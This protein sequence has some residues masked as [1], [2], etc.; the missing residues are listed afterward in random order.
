MIIQIVH[1][2]IA[3]GMRDAAIAR[4][5]AVGELMSRQCGFVFRHVGD[6]MDNP[7]RIT[8]VTAWEDAASLE[9]WNL[10]RLSMPPQPGNAGKVYVS[11]STC[12]METLT[13]S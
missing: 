9:Q 4:I 5:G 3:N 13:S 10:T 1:H 8:T 11:V 6:A 7:S 2:D 12:S